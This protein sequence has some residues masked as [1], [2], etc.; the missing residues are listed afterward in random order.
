MAAPFEI[1]LDVD[2]DKRELHDIA[3]SAFELVHHLE[4]QL[5]AYIPESDVC[6]INATAADRPA[7]LEP[8]IYELLKT[9]QRIHR[10]TEG[11]FDITT[12][13]LVRAWGFFQREG[14]LP[15]PSELEEARER[16]GMEFVHLDDETHSV[17]FA[18]QGIEINLGGIGKGYVIDRVVESLRDW[19]VRCALVHSGQSSIAV[20]GKP[21]A[22]RRA[23][24]WRL[25]V[26]DPRDDKQSLGAL[27]LTDSTMS[28]SGNW[29]QFFKLEGKIYSHII[30]A[31]T[32]YPVRGMLSTT[33]IGRSAAETDALATAFFVMG[34]E[35][36]RRHCEQRDDVGA[37]LVTGDSPEQIAVH[38]VGCTLEK[39]EQE[40]W[41]MLGKN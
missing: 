38:A 6:F 14:R 35:K 17:R 16:V 5:S 13:P 32:G 30:E 28:T 3:D 31:R 41:T 37:V 22:V 27:T 7:R 40:Q 29:K 8:R 10:E 33:V 18:K 25:G 9:A 1:L 15:A 21:P 2:R 34:A 19:E 12:G 23:E 20:I 24:G 36:T 11:A 39:G 26:A 4:R